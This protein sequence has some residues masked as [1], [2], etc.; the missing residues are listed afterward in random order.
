MANSELELELISKNQGEFKERV[1]EFKQKLPNLVPL[2]DQEMLVLVFEHFYLMGRKDE[3]RSIQ[4][5]LD[6][7][8]PLK[9]M[10]KLVKRL[11]NRQ[12]NGQ[13]NK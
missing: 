7:N 10:G 1:E 11:F 13:K 4:K 6:N 2:F 8:D 3:L 5:F 12:Q 9:T